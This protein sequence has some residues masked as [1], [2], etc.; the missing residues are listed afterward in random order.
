MGAIITSGAEDHLIEGLSFLPPSNTANYVLETRQVT[1]QAETGNSFDPVSSRVVRFRLADHGFLEASSVKLALTL[2]NKGDQLITPVGQM[3]SLFRR[4][5]LFASSQLIEDRIELATESSI[6]ERLKDGLRRINDSV[7]QHPVASYNSDIYATLG[8][9]KSRRLIA[10]TCFGCLNQPKW[11]PLHLVSGGLVLE[12]ELDDA[13]TAFNESGV[14]FEITDVK[15]F[16]NLHTIDSALA[17]SY[18]SHVLKGNP[19]HLHFTSVV[20]SRHL[21]NG[22]NFAISLVRG[23]TRLRQCFIVFFL[24]KWSKENKDVLLALQWY[25]QYRPRRF[26]LATSDRK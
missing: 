17:N 2:Q 7:E 1:Y 5:R 13:D 14:S 4:A 3:M 11:I 9:N 16:A 8:P 10:P 23:F 18:A 19:L 21:C 26:F 22:P 15:L 6:T 24:S 25:I 20:A 12:F